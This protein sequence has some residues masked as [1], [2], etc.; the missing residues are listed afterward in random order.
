MKEVCCKNC[1]AVIGHSDGKVFYKDGRLANEL[2]CRCGAVRRL[3]GKRQQPSAIE[4]KSFTLT[5][6]PA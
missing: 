2:P 6:G 5:L 3:H 4:A 1:R